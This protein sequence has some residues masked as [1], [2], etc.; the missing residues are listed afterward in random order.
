MF[1]W[2]VLFFLHMSEEWGKVLII[3]KWSINKFFQTV[4]PMLYLFALFSNNIKS[5]SILSYSKSYSNFILNLIQRYPKRHLIASVNNVFVKYIVFIWVR[6]VFIQFMH[7]LHYFV[8]KFSVTFKCSEFFR[9]IHKYTVKGTR[10]Q[11]NLYEIFFRPLH[12][13]K[14]LYEDYS[15]P[16]EL[17]SFVNLDSLWNMYT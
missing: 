16:A 6:N 1:S 11:E 14:W 15:K 9:V 3:F 8:R 5:Y 2:Y 17:T 13:C 10:E 4:C 7:S 12:S